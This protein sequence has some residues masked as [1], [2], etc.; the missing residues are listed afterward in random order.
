M[1]T[2]KCASQLLG[3]WAVHEE[4]FRSLFEAA[5]KITINA[6]PR[7]ASQPPGDG[8]PADRPG[9]KL[10]NGVAVVPLC[11]VMTKAEHSYTDALGGTAT[12]LTRRALRKAAADSSVQAI[13][14]H[15]KGPVGS[16]PTS[17]ASEC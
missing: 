16:N 8:I 2:G 5:R 6:G 10:V 17:S 7:P 11:G 1:T 9:Y 14:L 4:R 13:L 3:P 12:T 15:R